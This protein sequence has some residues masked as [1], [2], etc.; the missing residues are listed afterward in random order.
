MERYKYVLREMRQRQDPD[1]FTPALF[2]PERFLDFRPTD[3]NPVPPRFDEHYAP[4]R[5]RLAAGSIT[6]IGDKL[7]PIGLFNI[8]A[9]AHQ[10]WV[11]LAAAA[12]GGGEWPRRRLA[13]AHGAGPGRSRRTGRGG[14]GA[15]HPVA[16]APPSPGRGGAPHVGLIR[17][18]LIQSAS[19]PRWRV[20]LCAS[21]SA[22]RSCWW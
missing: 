16:P 9:V 15:P 1:L 18:H 21:S 12:V 2:E 22:L 14:G 11:E 20:A 5:A 19:P 6:Q 8:R 13:Q 4:I 3:T 7:V 10:R 17:T